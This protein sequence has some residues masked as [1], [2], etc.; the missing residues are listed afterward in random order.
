MLDK[1]VKNTN[2]INLF[3]KCGIKSAVLHCFRGSQASH[4]HAKKPIKKTLTMKIS[5]ES[6]PI[7]IVSN[8]FDT[9][10]DESFRLREL[11]HELETEH[12][13]KIV[14]CLS[15]EDAIELLLSRTDFGALV[16]DW[17]INR[18]NPA[19]KHSPASVLSA[20]RKR[21]P[22]IP[23]FLLTDWLEASDIPLEVINQLT[24]CLWKTSDTIE[25]LAGRIERHLVKYVKGLY[26]PFF[27][28]LI[29][30]SEE[31]KY[32][33]HTPGHMGGT[34]FL[35]NPSGVALFKF[36]GENIFRSDLSI[37]APELGSLLDHSGVTGD[38]ERNSARV[39]G[40][41]LTYYV[42]NGTSN[43]NQIIW[44]S[45]ALPD[46]VVFVD[47]N[48]HKSLNYA[49]VNADAYPIYMKPRRNRWGIMGPVKLSELSEKSVAQKIKKSKIIPADLRPKT[50]KIAAITNSTYDGVCYNV[51]KLK[52]ALEPIADN[53]HF[54]EAWYAYAKFYPIYDGFFGMTQDETTPTTPPIYVAQSTHKLLT[55]FSQ[56][57]ML[58]VKN[59][60]SRKINPDELN[61]A[62]MMHAST[63]P[64]YNM[65]ASLDVATQMMEDSG[66]SM[67]K[68]VIMMA[69]GLR[70]TVAKIA[71]ELK[72]RNP[73][74]WF[75]EIWQPRKV[76]VDKE[77]LNFENVPT[78]YLAISQSAWILNSCDDWHGFEEIEDGYAM[79]DPIKLTFI[80]P[81]INPD[82]SLSE[83][84]IPA[85][86]VTN[87]LLEEGIVC[88]KT[89]YYSFLLLNS[90]GTNRAKQET[91]LSAL[92]HFKNLYDANAPMEEAMS[93]FT[94]KNPKYKGI[95][96][97]D[98]CRA[99]HEFIKERKMLELMHKSFDLLPDQAMK[100][101]QAYRNVVK[102]NVELVELKDMFG[103]IPAVMIVPY[104]PGIPMLMGGEVLNK[105]SK[106][107]FDY[108]K[109]RES[110]ENKFCGYESEIHGIEKI[111]RDGKIRF[112]TMCIK[113]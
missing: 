78:Q 54:D 106:A 12:G 65:I 33:W 81:G 79:L 2:L 32:A 17:D 25:F 44:R 46:D 93:A 49:M 14:P 8:Q 88:E 59:G 84:G 13:C 77:I 69:I 3:F 107:V 102:K 75:F 97:K 99:M 27:G 48:C 63:S 31:Y 20:I 94:Q 91:L 6:W 35:R 19:A 9:R 16:I 89:D 50:L 53:L 74:D 45:I 62:Y 47:R 37:S 83:T 60:G 21:N 80:T 110:F 4:F 108:L 111:E 57:S 101:T 1:S 68:D 86:V 71:A 30:Y 40:A 82:G 103:R 58:H 105:K 43:V 42:L 51:K 98:H 112:C 29:D 70:K 56:A 90:L 10:N 87:Y 92:L 11:A 41:D 23:V 28:K 39:F 61:E 100:P 18:T 104:P 66:E 34:G 7:L 55:A 73:N 22:K 26:P 67:W 36:F 15:Y 24:G 109:A 72:S 76:K 38:A 95:G 96:L 52:R 64:Q 85:A 5:K 113:Q